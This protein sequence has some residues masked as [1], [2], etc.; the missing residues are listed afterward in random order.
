MPGVFPSSSYYKTEIL[1]L[2]Y[3]PKSL[4][5]AFSGPQLAFQLRPRCVPPCLQKPRYTSPLPIFFVT[6]L[7]NNLQ[8]HVPIVSAHTAFRFDLRD[9]ALAVHPARRLAMGMSHL[10]PKTEMT[11]DYPSL[12]V[13]HGVS[14]KEISLLLLNY[15]RF[16]QAA[17]TGSI[18][19]RQLTFV[20]IR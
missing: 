18:E 4:P 19:Q 17:K 2:G 14:C 12:S 10:K 13:K 7:P 9:F 16:F 1:L 6:D 8:G 5:A 11:H 3:P 15:N 20:R